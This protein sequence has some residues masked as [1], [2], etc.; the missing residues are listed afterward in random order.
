[1]PIARLPTLAAMAVLLWKEPLTTCPVAEVVQV[2]V[3]RHSLKVTSEMSYMQLT[4]SN[5]VTHA[6]RQRKIKTSA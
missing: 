5:L 6:L 3:I 4:K 2:F 1:M